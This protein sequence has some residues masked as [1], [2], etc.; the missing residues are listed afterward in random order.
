MYRSWM[1]FSGAGRGSDVAQRNPS[2]VLARSAIAVVPCR[3]GEF[4]TYL[5]GSEVHRLGHPTRFGRRLRRTLR[6]HGWVGCTRA[7]GSSWKALTLQRAW[8]S[9][10]LAGGSA[11]RWRLPGSTPRSTGGL[12][13]SLVNPQEHDLLELVQ[14]GNVR[15]RRGHADRDVGEEGRQAIHHGRRDVGGGLTCHRYGRMSVGLLLRGAWAVNSE[16]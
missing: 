4:T 3:G 7:R 2:E 12:I 11:G 14:V 6:S 15:I 1:D 9:P 8:G 16:P 5:I 10:S 13:G